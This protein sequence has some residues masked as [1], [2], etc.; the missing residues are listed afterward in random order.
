[1]SERITPAERWLDRFHAETFGDAPSP[2]V[3]ARS[4]QATKASGSELLLWVLGSDPVSM[5]RVGF[6]AADASRIKPVY[7]PTDKRGNGFGSAVTAAAAAWARD[8]GAD[9]V[10]LFTDLANPVS[11]AIYRRIGFRP[12]GQRLSTHRFH[13]TDADS[14]EAPGR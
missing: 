1:M 7:T 4:V 14:G 13:R 3:T 8:A 10:V 12:I 6:P 9:D 11:N 2:A 5:A